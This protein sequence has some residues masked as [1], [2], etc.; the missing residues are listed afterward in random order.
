METTEAPERPLAPE[1]A[2][3]C[4][5]TALSLIYRKER[6]EALAEVKRLTRVTQV[7]M[8][9]SDANLAAKDATISRLWAQLNEATNMPDHNDPEFGFDK[10]A[11][12]SDPTYEGV[13][14]ATPKRGCPCGCSGPTAALSDPGPFPRCTDLDCEE[15]RTKP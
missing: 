1:A 15:C 6:D 14:G 3:E 11:A 9:T 13:F 10:T 12:L 4:A 5:H 8:A 2:D 7:I